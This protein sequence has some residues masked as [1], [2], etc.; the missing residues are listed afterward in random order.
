[1]PRFKYK[2]APLIEV[3][4]QLRFPIILKIDTELPSNFQESIRSRYPNLNI[5]ET[6]NSIR[7]EKNANTLLGKNYQFISVDGKHR[8]SLTSSFLAISTLNYTQWEEFREEISSIENIFFTNYHP[9]FYSR[10]GL[11]YRDLLRRSIWGLSTVPWKELV[12]PHIIGT[13]TIEEE[14]T[15]NFSVHTETKDPE[16]NIS[17]SKNFSLVQIQNDQEKESALLLDC[18]YYISD[19]ISRDNFFKL[20]DDL[21]TES[22]FFIQNAITDRLS[23]AME[24]EEIG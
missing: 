4:Y 7:D 24:P 5:I 17:T 12:K 11:R 19:V 9:S 8:V 6:N 22:T 1:M 13:L 20:S 23:T 18:D 2:K 15:L 10:I 21:H 14:K 16:S 3:I